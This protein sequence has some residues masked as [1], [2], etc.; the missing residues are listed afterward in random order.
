MYV[1]GRMDAFELIGEKGS[2]CPNLRC[3]ALFSML[4]LQARKPYFRTIFHVVCSIGQADV[5]ARVFVRFSFEY[6]R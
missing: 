1:H 3:G 2:K 4:G 5:H 6:D